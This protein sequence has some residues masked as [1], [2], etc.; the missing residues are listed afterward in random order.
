VFPV[1]PDSLTAG[2]GSVEAALA[3]T[4]LLRIYHSVAANFPNPIFPIEPVV[5]QLGVDNIGVAVPEPVTAV[6]VLFGAAAAGARYR[7][8]F[9]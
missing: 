5:A 8:R 9:R 1:T 7:R 4:T 2:L 6:L 3:N